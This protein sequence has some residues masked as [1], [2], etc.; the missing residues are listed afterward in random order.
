MANVLVKRC[1]ADRP[2][3]KWDGAAAAYILCPSCKRRSPSFSIYH[4]GCNRYAAVS[5]R[6]VEAAANAWNESSTKEA[7]LNGR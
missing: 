1:C 3:L 2:V 7:V 4:C 5:R 6:A